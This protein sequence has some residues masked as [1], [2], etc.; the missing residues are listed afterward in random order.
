MYIAKEDGA[1]EVR[2]TAT[3]ALIGYV[4]VAAGAF[5]LKLTPDGTQLYASILFGGEVRVIDRASRT[6]V[7]T[8]P[9]GTD[10][11]R[12]AFDRYGRTAVITEQNGEVY[13]VR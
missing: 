6:L 10:P 13:F 5:G 8:I 7:R 4:P 12:I 3:G 9:I 11:R 2:A 1:M